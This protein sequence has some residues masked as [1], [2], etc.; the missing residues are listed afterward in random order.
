MEAIKEKDK[1]GCF[2][3]LGDLRNPIKGECVACSEAIACG[4]GRYPLTPPGRLAANMRPYGAFARLD[5]RDWRQRVDDG[6]D[7]EIKA[8]LKKYGLG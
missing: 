7:G 8:A 2:G 5:K 1:R 4:A 3:S 6:L